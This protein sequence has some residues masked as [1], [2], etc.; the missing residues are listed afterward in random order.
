M[1][2]TWHTPSYT[3]VDAKDWA[4]MK[5]IKIFVRLVL[6]PIFTVLS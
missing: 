1:D 2:K 5:K 6:G 4:E 3:T